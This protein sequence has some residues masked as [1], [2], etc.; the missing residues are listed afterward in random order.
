MSP[1]P[2]PRRRRARHTEA[3]GSHCGSQPSTYI[4]CDTIQDGVRRN[5]VRLG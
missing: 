1:S 4:R 2:R 5:R 3:R